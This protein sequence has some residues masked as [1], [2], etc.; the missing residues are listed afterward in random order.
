MEWYIQKDQ[1][2]ESSERKRDKEKER[3]KYCYTPLYVNVHVHVHP[4]ISVTCKIYSIFHMHCLV[5]S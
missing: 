1:Y 5:T 4:I 2:G 3:V